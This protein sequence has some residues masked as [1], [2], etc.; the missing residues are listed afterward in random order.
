MT[1]TPTQI[2]VLILIAL[3]GRELI[4]LA[5]SY[6][7]KKVTRDDYITKKDCE[8]CQI[9]IQSYITKND[10]E[11]CARTDDN[12]IARLSSEMATVKGILLVIAVKQG[13][14]PEDLTRLT[15]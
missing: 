11:A 7:F 9:R 1:L 12:V 2:A 15:E 3:V 14:P 6:F 5:T 10:C 13:I 4:T 8:A